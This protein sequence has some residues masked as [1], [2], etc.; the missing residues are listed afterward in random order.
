MVKPGVDPDGVLDDGAV[1]VN[2]FSLQVGDYPATKGY[3]V[4]DLATAEAWNKGPLV[5]AEESPPRT[6][7]EPA[8]QPGGSRIEDPVLE[9]I[10]AA[11]IRGTVAAFVAQPEVLRTLRYSCRRTGLDLRRHG[12]GEIPN[13]AAHRGEIVVIDVPPGDDRHFDWC[14]RIKDFSAETRVV[15]LLH[16]PSRPRVTQAFL[17]KADVIMGFPCDEA[18]LSQKLDGLLETAPPDEDEDLDL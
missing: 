15:L 18:Q 12:K 11:P 9:A 17:C 5:D 1:V 6:A 14:R 10:P 2:E 8:A 3:M 16:H 4:V 13:P 7:A